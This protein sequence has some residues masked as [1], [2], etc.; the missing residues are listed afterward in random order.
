MKFNYQARTKTGEIQAGVIEASSEEA[1]LALLQ[2]YQL[3][4]TFLEKAETPPLFERKIKLFERISPKE[5]VVFSR[6]LAIL[7]KSEVPPVEAL[8]ALID[9][10]KNLSFKEKILKI[11]ENVEGGISL[12]QAISNYPKIFSHFYISMIK[13]GEVSGNLP[14]SIENLADHLE[15]EITFKSKVIG[16]MIYPVF[17]LGVFLIILTAM[18][19]FIIPNLSQVLTASGVEAPFITK[20]VFKLSDFLRRWGVYLAVGFL[21]LLILVFRYSKT[22]EGKKFFDKTSLRIPILN[23]LLMK[24]YLSRFAE[25]LST[26]ISGGLAISRALEITGEVVGND[27]YR[28][29]IMETRD[30]VRKGERISV[31]LEKYPAFIPPLFIQMTTI[32]EKTGKLH[33]S[34]MNIVNFYQKEVDRALDNFMRLLEPIM[35]VFLGLIVAGLVGAVLLPMYSQMGGM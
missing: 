29:I 2:K 6:Q 7:F 17:V 14:Q 24:I 18:V 35:I 9:Q 13:T 3:F 27:L 26:L 11:A 1:A 28:K 5:V 21:I 30:G 22:A 34:L 16:A 19:V 10:T 31:I 4:V 20:I 15:R 12:S 25:N 32:G 33:A 8:H 23:S